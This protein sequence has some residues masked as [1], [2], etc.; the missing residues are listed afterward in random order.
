M[1]ERSFCLA[2]NKKEFSNIR[3]ALGKSQEEMAKLLGISTKAIQSFEQ[4]WRKVPVYAERQMYFLMYLKKHPEKQKSCWVLNQC[5]K[6]TRERCPAWEFKASHLCWF[7][8]GTICHGTVQ[9]NWQKKI[10][11]CRKCEVFQRSVGL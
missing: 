10:A 1:N 11:F 8:N 5:P 7:I 3:H 9:K 6:E 2:M 4:G